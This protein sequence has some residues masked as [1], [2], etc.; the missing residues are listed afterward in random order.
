MSDK[1]SGNDEITVTDMEEGE[2]DEPEI[3]EV[4]AHAEASVK[5]AKSKLKNC[6]EEKRDLLEELQRTK[7]DFLNS[8]KRLSEQLDS[9][10]E[11][12]TD[13]I[14]LDM[15]PLLDSLE[16]ALAESDGAENTWR[17]GILA[18]HAQFRSVL[19]TYDITEIGTP[20]ESFDPHKHEAISNVPVE[21]SDDDQTIVTVIQQGYERNRRVLRPARVA[22]GVYNQ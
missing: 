4:E 20:G 7:A 2:M 1:K 15:L 16:L 22:V 13:R 14:F 18:I 5:S 19:S 10:R 9:D 8:K 6:E 3:E 17:K 21:S 12:I 11:K